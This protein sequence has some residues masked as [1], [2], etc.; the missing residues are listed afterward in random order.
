[1]EKSWHG[2][3]S[4]RY[5]G[6]GRLR[7]T[8]DARRRLGTATGHQPARSYARP[9]WHHCPAGR[10]GQHQHR[11]VARICARP[12]DAGQCGW[13]RTGERVAALHGYRGRSRASCGFMLA[14][15]GQYFYRFSPM[16]LHFLCLLGRQITGCRGSPFMPTPS[17]NFSRY[18]CPVY[19]HQKAHVFRLLDSAKI[20][21]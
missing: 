21:S 7:R 6:L 20:N 8:I 11:P 4:C 1:M 10:G 14:T 19:R 2:F 9:A 5:F 12:H 18:Y 16:I 15:S 3:L 17:N 13:I